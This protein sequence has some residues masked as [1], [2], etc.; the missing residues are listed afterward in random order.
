[1]GSDY[2]ICIQYTEADAVRGALQSPHGGVSLRETA[3][4]P[5]YAEQI[6]NH[7]VDEVI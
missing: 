7:H 6:A 4:G 1:M 2:S 3:G 5:T